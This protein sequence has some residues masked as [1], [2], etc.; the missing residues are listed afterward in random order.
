MFKEVQ[1]EICQSDVL[2]QNV[3]RDPNCN[4]WVGKQILKSQRILSLDHLP[5]DSNQGQYVE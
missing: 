4:P 2:M 5:E 3:K 1:F